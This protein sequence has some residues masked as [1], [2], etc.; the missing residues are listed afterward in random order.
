MPFPK[1]KGRLLSDL[2][3]AFRQDIQFMNKASAL[4]SCSLLSGFCLP[5]P[6][7]WPKV[8]RRWVRHSD[9]EVF[10]CL[11]AF[12]SHP[13]RQWVLQLNGSFLPKGAVGYTIATIPA[14]IGIQN[15]RRST[16]VWIWHQYIPSTYIHACITAIT[17]IRVKYYRS[18]GH[19][20]IW[21]HIS[22]LSHTYITPYIFFDKKF[23]KLYLFI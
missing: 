4:H 20:R 15:D 7:W 16:F 12:P 22:F 13:L 23:S 8:W 6:D 10:S 1:S 11:L 18:A 9:A 14:F 5:A 2:C 21:N 17:N 19:S 3:A